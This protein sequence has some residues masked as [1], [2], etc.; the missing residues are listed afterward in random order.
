MKKEGYSKTINISGHLMDLDVPRVMG[1]LNVT[2]DSFY[3][4]SRTETQEKIKARAKKLISE[5]ADIIDVGGCSTRP[6]YKAPSEIDEWERVELGCK[7]VRELSLQIPLSVDT[8]RAK[9]AYE[10]IKHFNVNIINDISGGEDKDIWKVAADQGVSYVLTHN[11][12]IES[13]NKDITAIVISELSKKV[14]ELHRL[15]VKDVI[16]DPGFGFAKS[17]KEN[18]QLLEELDEIVKT[19]YPVLVGVSRKSMIYKTLNLTPEESLTGTISLNTIALLKG[20]A[21]LRVHDV[22]EASEIVRLF[23]KLKESTP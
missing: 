23:I 5:G 9:V 21:I 1:I 8:F 18:F 3:A 2:P 4:S 16:V 19:G 11:K 7:V 10:A 15:G 17:Q 14:N 13:E 20:A 22:K 6:G 12:L